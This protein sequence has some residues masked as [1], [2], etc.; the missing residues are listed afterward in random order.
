MNTSPR[1][2]RRRQQKGKGST[3]GNEARHTHD[4]LTGSMHAATLWST[5]ATTMSNSTPLAVAVM[6]WARMALRRNGRS[7]IGVGSIVVMPAAMVS[8]IKSSLMT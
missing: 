4:T 5:S 7:T 2:K 3:Q 8:N 6:W 1:Y